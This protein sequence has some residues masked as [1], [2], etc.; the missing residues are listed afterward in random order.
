MKKHRYLVKN[1]FLAILIPQKGRPVAE[2]PV[3]GK[4]VIDKRNRLVYTVDEPPVFKK[5]YR[6]PD[7]ITFEGTWSLDAAHNLVLSGIKNHNLFKGD[8]I[9]IECE[10][11]DTS[12]NA[13]SVTVA[14]KSK[15]G[16][17]TIK[18]LQ[19]AG[20]WQADEANR[21]CFRVKKSESAYDILTFEGE[22]QA[23]ENNQLVYRYT[24]TYLK[25]KPK[26]ER[27][28]IFKGYWDITG[29]DRLVYIL[30][31][32]G[33][34][35]FSFK[36][37]MQSP[38]LVGKD[39]VIKYQLGIGIQA[40]LDKVY[41]LSLYGAWKIEKKGSISF[42]ID[43]GAAG[44]K[45]VTFGAS[46]NLDANDEIT[47]ELRAKT[48]KPISASVAFNRDFWDDQA[49]AFLRLSRDGKELKAE[50]GVAILW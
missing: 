37:Q 9:T 20:A 49:K 38:S 31:L 1:N 14:A 12:S 21:I 46:A 16:T 23:G 28:L 32:S 36:A 5:K 45:A 40:K 11:I 48:G 3:D 27:T 2:I 26:S 24:K 25:R 42:D 41:V 50:G 30:N 29:Q 35:L 22:W 13:L 44:V 19:L 18:L 34:S 39:G 8:A 7:K 10:I 47:F 17:E 15:D 33:P 43:Y 4:F 6:L